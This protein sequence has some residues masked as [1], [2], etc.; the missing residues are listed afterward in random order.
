MCLNWFW[1]LIF[2]WRFVEADLKQGDSMLKSYKKTRKREELLEAL[3]SYNKAYSSSREAHSQFPTIIINYAIALHVFNEHFGAEKDQSAD[4]IRLFNEAL[5]I[6][7]KK[8]PRPKGYPTVLI[9]LGNAYM[10][11]YHKTKAPGTVQH[12]IE[13]FDKARSLEDVP[14]SNT[15][16]A[17]SFVGSASAICISCEQDKTLEDKQLDKAMIYLQDAIALSE[18]APNMQAECYRKLASCHDV[19]YQ[20]HPERT[21]DLNEAIIANKKA[22]DLV[23]DHPT[24]LFNLS[25]E[26]FARY[27][28]T[29]E[30]GDLE[31]AESTAEEVQESAEEVSALGIKVRDLQRKIKAYKEQGSTMLSRDTMLS[32]SS[33]DSGIEQSPNGVGDAMISSE[34]VLTAEPEEIRH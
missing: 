9:N 25:K 5:A 24:T 21:N 1:N 11:Q 8:S 2:P 10:F 20:R 13:A 17:T 16:R 32:V 6:W 23:E 22:L 14:I 33:M 12:A 30:Q 7:D 19:Y 26:Y 15:V 18:K 34:K 4:V 3:S 29:K 28:A 27:A 31:L